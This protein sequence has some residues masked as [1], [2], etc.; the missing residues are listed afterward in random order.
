MR[1]WCSRS[2]CAVG[3]CTLR[4]MPCRKR[5]S[6]RVHDFDY[7]GES[8]F[9]AGG[10]DHLGGGVE[11]HINNMV[12][13]TTANR[14]PEHVR[15]LFC[16]RTAGTLI[17]QKSTPRGG[18]S[19]TRP[20]GAM[21]SSTIKCPSRRSPAAPRFRCT[22]PANY[23]V[24]I[25]ADQQLQNAPAGAPGSSECVSERTS[26]V[27]VQGPEQIV[28]LHIFPSKAHHLHMQLSEDLIEDARAPSDFFDRC[29]SHRRV[30]ETE[31]ATPRE[32]CAPK[33]L[34]LVLRSYPNDTPRQRRNSRMCV[35]KKM[36]IC[37]LI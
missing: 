21:R 17:S 35:F 8:H 10:A 1:A 5:T 37:H 13:C 9:N 30:P 26:L 12:A 36:I 18:A 32:S 6:T 25:D 15:Y 33:P 2:T 20:G 31:P 34:L 27:I 11:S 23:R 7:A 24:R 14:R 4:S 16:W 29:K 3:A 22:L 28:V 19:W